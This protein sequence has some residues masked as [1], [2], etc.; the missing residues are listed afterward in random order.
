LSVVVR[1]ARGI[2]WRRPRGHFSCMQVGPTI[3]TTSMC[4]CSG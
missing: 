1:V 4:Q 3:K 2:A